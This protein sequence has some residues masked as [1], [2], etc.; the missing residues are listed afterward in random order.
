MERIVTG[1]RLKKVR[2]PILALKEATPEI[3]APCNELATAL[4][5]GLAMGVY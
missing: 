1:L 3:I 5:A 2:E 4:A